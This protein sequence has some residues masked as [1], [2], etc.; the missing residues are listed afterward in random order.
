MRKTTGCNLEEKPWGFVNHTWE[1]LLTFLNN[2][3]G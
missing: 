1:N 2:L 3:K